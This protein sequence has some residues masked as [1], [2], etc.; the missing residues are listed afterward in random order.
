MADD[1]T[2]AGSAD[3]SPDTSTDATTEPAAP[4]EGEQATESP[5]ATSDQSAGD[6]AGAS[7]DGPVQFVLPENVEQ[8]DDEALRNLGAEAER[9]RAEAHAAAQAASEA[10]TASMDQ[11]RTVRSLRD[12]AERVRTILSERQASREQARAEL[13]E[14]A[15]PVELPDATPAQAQR[16]AA[17]QGVTR[18][19]E[20]AP[21]AQSATE[22][23]PAERT[24]AAAEQPVPWRSTDGG[25]TLAWQEAY[26]GNV[27][28]EAA[29]GRLQ[30]QRAAILA[31]ARVVDDPDNLLADSP[32]R[33]ER[34]IAEA[35]EAHRAARL[36][37][38]GGDKLA[39]ICDPASILR[40]A[41]VCGSTATPFQS[42]LVQLTAQSG[43]QL[44]YEYR[45]PTSIS[46]ATDGIA[47]WTA[48]DQDSVDPTDPDTWKP[49]VS[50]ACASYDT[51]T[52]VEQTAS[53]E[54][55]A[56]TALSSPESVDDFVQAKDRA[57]ARHTEGW[58]LRKMDSFLH[59]FTWDGSEGP[60]AVPKVIE[61]VLT[62]MA[63]GDF[64]ERLDPGMGYN[65]YGS[66]GLL[67]ALAIDA[68]RKGY[69]TGVD[70]MNDVRGAV[71]AATGTEYVQLLDVPHT[72]DA[73]T[74]GSSPF[75]ALPAV[76]GGG[77]ALPRLDAVTF[78]LRVLDPSSFAAFNTGEATFG[79]Q[80]TLDQAR[81][82]KRGF[83]QRMFGGLMKPGCAPGYK[84]TVSNL[85][86]DGSRGGFLTP[87]AELTS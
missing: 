21:A 39:A 6:E 75:T 53:Y 5:D 18:V 40:D 42:S 19:I 24:A 79:E 38:G 67:Y 13:E 82:N 48:T 4:A 57:F 9:L 36:E 27:Q 37:A 86:V 65:V 15:A 31:S 66:P 84:I 58:H 3:E 8:L 59:H 20:P 71:Q 70:A 30:P 73:G 85:A 78:T 51:E 45:L 52:A 32:S 62:A 44:K 50:I 74:W 83:F 17:A 64:A 69:R 49:T 1:A 63:Q 61:A 56:F 23:Q 12:S 33:N 81:Q 34:I 7:D 28:P 25:S 14:L 60:G 76:G 43:N 35:M 11:V 2:T 72:D 16:V 26:N 54:V 77:V 68:N 80:I 47:T 87:D 10:G 22:Q 46:T 41:F 29:R 55:D